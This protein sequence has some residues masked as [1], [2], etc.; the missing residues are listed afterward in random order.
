MSVLADT[1]GYVVVAAAAS[2]VLAVVVLVS[3]RSGIPGVLEQ[4]PYRVTSRT[5][6]CPCTTASR[7][8]RR[9]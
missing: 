1:V 9:G 2:A 8:S 3:R 5:R 7:S 4:W 6:R